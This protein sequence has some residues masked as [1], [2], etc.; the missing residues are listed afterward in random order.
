MD[1]ASTCAAAVCRKALAADFQPALV[2]LYGENL[3]TITKQ[4]STE[5]RF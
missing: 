2:K 4:D 1:R 3:V 5:K